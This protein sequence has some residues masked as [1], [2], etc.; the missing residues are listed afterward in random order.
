MAV[1]NVKFR[2]PCPGLRSSVQAKLSPPVSFA[3]A[4]LVLGSY[5]NCLI[6]SFLTYKTGFKTIAV[7][8]LV[9]LFIVNNI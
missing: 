5:L 8:T 6:F 3:I 7:S 4:E 9:G 2:D 1:T